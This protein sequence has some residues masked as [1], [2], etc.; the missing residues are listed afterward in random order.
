MARTALITDV[1]WD[2]LHRE[3]AVLAAAGIE[4]VDGRDA[5]DAEL[6]RLARSADAI[7]TC[8]RTVD[9]AMLA[10]AE[11]CV[12]VSRYGVGLDNINVDAATELGMVVTNVPDY[13]VEEVSDHTLALLLAHARRIPAYRDGTRSGG[14]DRNAI[15]PLRRLSSQTIGL[16]GYGGIG[17]RVAEKAAAF[18]MGVLACAPSRE[19]GTTEAPV[20]FVALPDLLARSDYVSL[21]APLSAATRHLLGPAEFSAMRPGAYLINTARGGLVDTTALVAALESGHLAGAG[22]DVLE[23]EPPDPDDVLRRIE[24]VTLTPHAAFDSVESVDAVATR[25]AAHAV[26]VL[27]GDIP[28]NIVNPEVLRRPNLRLPAPSRT[29][30]STTTT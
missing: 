10:G 1:A 4:A 22:L 8:W 24:S 25:A 28:E 15:G 20:E 2:D 12:T 19:P 23:S 3:Q 26:A 16:V 14:W 21:H 5:N 17:R 29:I 27:A 18:G 11:R 7:L 30:P 9:A 13:C 6:A